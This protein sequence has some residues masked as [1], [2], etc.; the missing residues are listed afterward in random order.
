MT[1][2]RNNPGGPIQPAGGGGGPRPAGWIG[3]A[4]VVAMTLGAGISL[5]TMQADRQTE[6]AQ[7]ET[8]AS[9]QPSLAASAEPAA[10][11]SVKAAGMPRQPGWQRP[12]NA[13]R[14]ASGNADAALDGD[15]VMEVYRQLYERWAHTAERKKLPGNRE[16]AIVYMELGHDGIVRAVSLEES[17]GNAKLDALAMRTIEEAPQFEPFPKHMTRQSVELAFYF[18]PKT[19]VLSPIGEDGKPRIEKAR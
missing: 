3:V 19:L 1:Q 6:R 16:Q 12:D 18:T 2:S 5:W 9:S 7:P 13:P 11:S 14:A 15:Y 8:E 4:M 10:E 17:S